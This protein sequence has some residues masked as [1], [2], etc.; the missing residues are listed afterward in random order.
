MNK[1]LKDQNLVICFPKNGKVVKDG[2]T[3]G[4]WADVQL[5]QEKSFN[6]RGMRKQGKLYHSPHLVNG[7]VHPKNG[8]SFINHLAFYKADEVA[9]MMKT[10]TKHGDVVYNMNDEFVCN[11]DIRARHVDGFTQYVEKDIDSFSEPEKKEWFKGTRIGVKADLTKSNTGELKIKPD[12]VRACD[13]IVDLDN[14]DNYTKIAQDINNGT[15]KPDFPNDQS[16]RNTN[17]CY[18]GVTTYFDGMRNTAKMFGY[19]LEMIAHDKL[20][21]RTIKPADYDGDFTVDQGR[22]ADYKPE[23][24]Q[25]ANQ[26]SFD[27]SFKNR[28]GDTVTSFKDLNPAETVKQLQNIVRDNPS[29]FLGRDSYNCDIET[30]G[31]HVVDAYNENEFMKQPYKIADKSIS[32]ADLDKKLENIKDFETEKQDDLEK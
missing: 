15:F 6:V 16:R 22:Y 23:R 30:D 19:K 25:D 14:Q 26:Y 7:L 10:A 2:K 28:D 27:L 18:A 29:A 17:K 24:Q 20:N 1:N 31:L 21:H 4:Y 32:Q 3:I 12:T 13:S 11:P 8:K 5:A 9:K